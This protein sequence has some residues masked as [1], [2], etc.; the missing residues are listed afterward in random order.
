MHQVLLNEWI[1][2]CILGNHKESL[3]FDSA[4]VKGFVFI[5]DKLMISH[6]LSKSIVQLSLPIT[7][8]FYM[9]VVLSATL[10]HDCE[11][12]LAGS[13]ESLTLANAYFH[14]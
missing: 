11:R 12:T 9:S 10:S 1:N 5:R 6:D 3:V 4:G 8:S 2:E 14:V 13:E 7:T